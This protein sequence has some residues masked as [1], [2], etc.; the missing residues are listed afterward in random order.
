MRRRTLSYAA[1]HQG[2]PSA[3]RQHAQTFRPSVLLNICKLKQ[4]SSRWQQVQDQS[5]VC[6]C[7]SVV[8]VRT[9]DVCEA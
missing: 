7:E 5:S 2:R 3:H 6:L 1:K 9:A 4:E 8:W